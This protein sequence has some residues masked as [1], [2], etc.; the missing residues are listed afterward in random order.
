MEIWTLRC[1]ADALTSGMRALFIIAFPI[2]AL[3]FGSKW[4]EVSSYTPNVTVVFKDETKETGVLSRAWDSRYVLTRPDG[5]SIHF[6]DFFMIE[7]SASHPEPSSV[8]Q[9]NWRLF[10]CLVIG[11]LPGLFVLF[12]SVLKPWTK[13]VGDMPGKEAQAV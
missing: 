5:V 4:E 13:C 12:K 11:L 1:T 10:I 8:L 9:R 3:W 7:H 2:L 6:R